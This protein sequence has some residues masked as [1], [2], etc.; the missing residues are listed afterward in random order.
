MK[1]KIVGTNSECAGLRSRLDA[2]AQ[3]AA[4]NNARDWREK[5]GTWSV[6]AAAAGASLALTTSATADIIYSGPQNLTTS[7]FTNPAACYPSCKAGRNINIDGQGNSFAIF[8]SLGYGGFNPTDGGRLSLV[9][10]R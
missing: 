5:L 2:Y 7:P 3:S 9:N 4:V 10:G 6:F 8:A 1:E